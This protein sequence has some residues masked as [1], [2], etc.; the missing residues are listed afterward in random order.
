MCFNETK[1]WHGKQMVDSRS[2]HII[3]AKSIVFT[4]QGWV[5]I[6]PVLY[7]ISWQLHPTRT[8]QSSR[9]L[10]TS[11]LFSGPCS[12]LWVC[13]S[14]TISVSGPQGQGP[15]L[16]TFLNSSG[17]QD[18][19]QGFP[20]VRELNAARKRSSSFKSW[21]PNLTHFSRH[22]SNLQLAFLDH[23]CWK[24]EASLSKHPF[25]KHSFQRQE[26]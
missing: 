25:E 21:L 20:W 17:A 1:I 26:P 5:Q 7:S 9:T 22:V 23:T 14:S 12:T 19:M 4:H 11:L 13:H 10:V 3:P 8:F 2:F 6:L 18:Y 16:P 24:R 15:W